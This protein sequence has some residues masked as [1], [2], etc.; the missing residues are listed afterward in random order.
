M[1]FSSC[2]K[3]RDWCCCF[4]QKDLPPAS[5][6]NAMNEPD[7]TVTLFN[8]NPSS[9]NST[10]KNKQYSLSN[11]DLSVTYNQIYK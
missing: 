1:I 6:Y 4:K 2:K 11:D 10:D 3:I 5:D 7:V 9:N 8:T